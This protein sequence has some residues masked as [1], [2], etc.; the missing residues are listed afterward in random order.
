MPFVLSIFRNVACILHYLA[1]L[2]CAPTHFFSTPNYVLLAPKNPLFN[3]CFA[4]FVMCFMA[5]TG[6]V[7]AISLDIYTF[8]LSFSS[9]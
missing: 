7:Y 2:V 5:L 8:R 6:F 9:T 1:F 4:F 3:A